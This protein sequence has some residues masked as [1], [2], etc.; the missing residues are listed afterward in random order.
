M[1]FGAQVVEFTYQNVPMLGNLNNG[2]LVGLTAEG[3]AVC[4]KMFKDDASQ[5]EIEAVDKDL[6]TTLENGGYFVDQIIEPTLRSVY[7]HITQRCNLSCIGCYSQD[8]NRNLVSDA[9]L[10]NIKK[11]LIRL[12]EQHVDHIVISGGEPFLRDDLQDIVKHAK[13]MCG[14]K[15][16]DILSN[17]LEI[18]KQQLASVA[19]YV[20]HV[21]VSLDSWSENSPSHVR[22]VKDFIKLKEAVLMIKEAGI[23]AHLIVTIHAKN[24]DDIQEYI[25]LS[26]DLGTTLNFSLLSS[27][28]NSSDL[29][30]L[31]PNNQDLEKLS[32]VF[33]QANIDTPSAL[34]STPVGPHVFVRRT[35]GAGRDTI[36]V[37]YD[38]TVYPCHMLHDPKLSLGSIFDNDLDEIL[39]TPLKK[40]LSSSSVELFDECSSCEIKFFCGGGCRAR[41]Y[42]AF[43]NL[44]SKDPYCSLM[45][46]YYANY[47]RMMVGT[48]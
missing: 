4:H 25:K 14:F 28:L 38:G 20:D 18:T 11:A 48:T 17:G 37:S 45:K 2:Y 40:E 44:K 3:F 47:F 22:L 12:S 26:K 24:I 46:N 30:G 15:S 43:E 21:S 19:K 7:F 27:S 32:T 34:E 39:N 5:S 33:M 16:I 31:L 23:A 35:C 10:S 1:K 42:Y 13:N 36:S 8:N 6:F 41:S 9:S 29:K